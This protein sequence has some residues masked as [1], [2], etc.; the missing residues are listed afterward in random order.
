MF[1]QFSRKRRRLGRAWVKID[2][3]QLEILN[4]ISPKCFRLLIERYKALC[5]AGGLR[6]TAAPLK[7]L[8]DEGNR[9]PTKAEGVQGLCPAL[10][11]SFGESDTKEKVPGG[12]K[13]TGGRKLKKTV[14]IN[15]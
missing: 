3:H 1:T 2:P 5:K 12:K 14:K 9:S 6:G 10:A 11:K 13:R 7:I 4:C 8:K 15:F